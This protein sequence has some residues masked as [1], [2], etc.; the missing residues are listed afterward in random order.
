M[1]KY[2]KLVRHKKIA[3]HPPSSPPSLQPAS[4]Q[5]LFLQ[6]TPLSITVFPSCGMEY[7]IG[8]VRSPVLVLPWCSPD[9]YLEMSSMT[10]WD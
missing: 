1:Y 9:I 8:Q 7:L 10:S 4:K 5:W 6:T 3:H 2:T